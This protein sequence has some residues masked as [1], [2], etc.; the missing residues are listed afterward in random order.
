MNA[1]FP[2]R[3]DR[4]Q[5]VPVAATPTALERS[6]VSNETR[7]MDDD[8]PSVENA[9]GIQRGW[10]IIDSLWSGTMDRA[11][12]HPESTLQE[13]V[14]GE[15]S[16][17]ETLRHLIFVTDAWVGR[18]ILGDQRAYH[19]LGLPPDGD[20]DVRPWGIEVD[21]HPSFE[22]V[23]QARAD[24]MQTVRALVERLTPSEFARMCQANPAPGFPPVTT[25]PVGFCLGVV[26]SEEHAHHGYAARDLS[27]LERTH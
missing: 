27:A 11:N 23:Q 14:N 9:D 5:Q 20:V 8:F 19:R 26:V 1:I 4:V 21:A 17:V 10:S 24:R 13:R 16:F 18:T 6:F 25:L 7:V 22:E 2:D 3:E 15:W 12:G